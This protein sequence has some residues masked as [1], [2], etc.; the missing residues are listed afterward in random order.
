MDR[1]DNARVGDEFIL[2]EPHMGFGTGT[3]V[4][5][6]KDDD[7]DMA[8]FHMGQGGQL[9]HIKWHRLTTSHLRE[10][11]TLTAKVERL[12]AE[13]EKLKP[14]RTYRYGDVFSLGPTAVKWIITSMR[15]D[16]IGA[17][18]I[19]TGASLVSVRVDFAKALTMGD[20]DRVLGIGAKYL[21]RGA[22][23]KE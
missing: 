6:Y 1:P 4:L 19:D 11:Q 13:L 8:R 12:E 21:G 14:E 2:A 17:T 23:V 5:F 15:T 3:S 18:C 10:L 22:T 20:I 9:N 16:C 7:F